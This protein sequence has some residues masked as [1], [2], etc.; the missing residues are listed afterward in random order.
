MQKT[1]ILG[2]ILGATLSGPAMAQDYAGAARAYFETDI[3]P[4]M[5]H[6]MIVSAIR[7]QNEAHSGITQAQIDTL[8]Q[9]WM[10]EVGGSARPTIDPVMNNPVSDLLREIVTRSD[11]LIADIFV[12]D[13]VGLNVGA[14]H[15][16]SDY[17]Q[18]DEAKHQQTHGIGPGAY[19]VGEV[20][21]DESTQ[22]FAVQVSMAIVDPGNGELIG[23]VTASIDADALVD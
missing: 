11:G 16:T 15:V 9:A 18:G 5:A 4:Q 23:A 10:A 22:I 14:S 12:M 3:A 6:Q 17:W 7:A 20:E 19:H 8:D 2:T 13:Y 21:F 1:L